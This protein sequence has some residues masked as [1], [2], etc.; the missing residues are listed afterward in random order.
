MFLFYIISLG[1][2][3]IKALVV[4]ELVVE[5]GFRFVPELVDLLVQGSVVLL[6][7]ADLVAI[8]GILPLEEVEDVEGVL[9]VDLVDGYLIK[10][11]FF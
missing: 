11:F 1:M 8:V 2:L 6:Q 5:V 3:K 10:V 4:Q 9:D 7:L